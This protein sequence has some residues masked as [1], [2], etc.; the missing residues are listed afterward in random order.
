L[1][2]IIEYEDIIGSNTKNDV[3]DHNLQEA[4]VFD[5][6]NG[7]CDESSEWETKDDKTHTKGGKE[8]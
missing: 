3:N 5:L 1:I 2:C 4:E 6:K 8:A 7:V